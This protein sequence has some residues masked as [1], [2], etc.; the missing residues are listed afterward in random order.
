MSQTYALLSSRRY[1][2]LISYPETLRRHY[3]FRLDDGLTIHSVPEP[4]EL[5]APFGSFSV[6]FEIGEHTI[7]LYEELE[8][9][10]YRIAAQEYETFRRFCNQVDRTEESEVII[11]EATR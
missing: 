5:K 11:R 7:E 4:V 2:L 3:T 1:D 9:T 10:Q 8:I 6:R